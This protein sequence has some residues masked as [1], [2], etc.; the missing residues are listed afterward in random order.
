M[1]LSMEDRLKRR[2][3]DALKRG[4]HR[5]GADKSVPMSTHVIGI[6]KSGAEAIGEILRTREV[7]SPRITALAIDIG[8]QNLGPLRKLAEDISADQA[9]ITIVSLDVP[10]RDDLLATLGQYGDFLRLEYPQYKWREQPSWLDAGTSLPAAGNHFPRAVAKAIYGHAYYSAPRSLERA[11]RAFAAGVDAERSQAAVAIIFG[12]GGGTGSGIAVDLA[13]HLSNRLFGRRVLVAG[14]GIAPCAG[15]APEHSGGS[16]FPVFNE[17]DVLSDEAKNRGVTIS[18]GELFRNPFTAGFILVPQQH[19]FSKTGDLAA[20][21]RW[22]DEQ[23]ATLIGGP[24]G[25]NLWELL[26]LLNWV[27]AP[28][29]QHSAART[30]WGAQWIHMLGSVDVTEPAA[31]ATENLP[32]RLGLLPE[33]HPEFIEIRTPAADGA[34][35]ELAAA[36]QAVFRPDVP[37]QVVHGNRDGAAQ[38]ILP[39]I[40]KHDLALFHA[41]RTA[42]QGQSPDQRRLGHAL[43]LE[44]GVLLCE[45]STKLDGMAGASLSDGEAWIAVPLTDVWGEALPDTIVEAPSEERVPA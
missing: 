4:V 36:V 31:M 42:Y 43:L 32:A 30:P 7:G 3:L 19:I 17:L 5:I 21:H 24:G 18:C 22:I 39:R 45:P 16:L 35:A 6:G 28:S 2:K 38:F 44:Q 1:S 12:L 9:K 15:D 14:I 10:G 11:L 26:R 33:Y 20:T 13:R 37:P 29:T 25:S 8:D 40:G 41:A 34:A 23:I 27:A